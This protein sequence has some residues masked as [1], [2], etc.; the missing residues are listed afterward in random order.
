MTYSI[1]DEI[2]VTDPGVC[3]NVIAGLNDTK[4][5]LQETVILPFPMPD[6]F[7]GI[8]RPWK[9]ILMVGP[10]GTGKMVLAKAVATEYRTQFFNVSALTLTSKHASQ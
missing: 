2:L 8:C 3:W 9:G 7:R 5:L 6:F 1:E 4:G 10:P